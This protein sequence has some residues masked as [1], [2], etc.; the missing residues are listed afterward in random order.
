MGG[1]VVSWP[2]NSSWI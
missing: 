1:F 2:V